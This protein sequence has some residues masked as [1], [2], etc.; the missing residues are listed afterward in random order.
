MGLFSAVGTV[1]TIIFCVSFGVIMLRALKKS[2]KGFARWVKGVSGILGLLLFLMFILTTLY[3]AHFPITGLWITVSEGLIGC[4]WLLWGCVKKH[5]KGAWRMLVG[6]FLLALIL[7]C[8]FFMF[9]IVITD[10]AC[11]GVY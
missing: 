10:V 7:A 2:P 1:A 6:I 5:L 9:Y 3:D 4:L 8:L 11:C